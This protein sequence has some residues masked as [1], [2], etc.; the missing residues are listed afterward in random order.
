MQSKHLREELLSNSGE[1]V[2]LQSPE[3]GRFA[4][5]GRHASNVPSW[6]P[7]C[8]VCPNSNEKTEHQMFVPLYDAVFEQ[9]DLLMATL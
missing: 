5:L 3:V 4:H 9:L 2:N 1:Q 8:G 7:I 6:S